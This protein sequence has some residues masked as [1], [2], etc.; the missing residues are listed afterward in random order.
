L[1]SPLARGLFAS[2]LLDGGP[3]TQF[4]SPTLMDYEASVYPRGAGADVVARLGC[5]NAADVPACLRAVP[6]ATIVKTV[7]GVGGVFNEVTYRAV[8]DG[9]VLSDTLLRTAKA[10]AHNHVPLIIGG[11]ARETANPSAYIPVSADPDDTAY[12]ADVYKLF[13]QTVGDQVLALYPSSNYPTPRDAFIAVTTDYKFLCPARRL[14]RAV[15]NSQ[16]EPVYRFVF[17][18][19]QSSPP[20]ATA[21]GAFHGEELLFIFHTFASGGL[22]GVFTPTADEL[23]L[24][25]QMIGYWTRFAATGNPNGEATPLP[26][27]VSGQNADNQ[28]QNHIFF[29]ADA[30]GEAKR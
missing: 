2:I 18:H 29:V 28:G 5:A 21:Q 12:K 26:W 20:V 25:D 9:A 27:F 4:D 8:I 13:G 30:Q 10:G 16:K 17:T 22:F 14:A 3:F 15:S 1:A 19:A 24:S 11:G 7:P 23:T 6:S